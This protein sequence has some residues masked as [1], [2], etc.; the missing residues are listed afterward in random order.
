M[1]QLGLEAIDR[2]LPIVRKKYKPDFILAQGENAYQGKGI[3]RELYA[4]LI[5]KGIDFLTGGNWTL[6]NQDIYP[7]LE[8]NQKMILRPA[9]YPEGTVGKK[10]KFLKT[11][12]GDVLVVSILGNIVGKDKDLK[13]NNPLVEIDQILIETKAIPKIATLVNFHGDYSSQKIVFGH[14]LDG[15]VTAVIGDHWH[16]PSADARILKRQTAYISDVGMVGSLNSSLGVKVEIILNRWKKDIK[17]RNELEEK[18]DLQLNG[19]Y[20]E[21]DPN[22]QKSIKSELI[23]RYFTLDK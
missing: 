13:L 18:D 15:K 23:Q 1:G 3:T 7:Y 12:Q 8:D 10:Y 16:V 22:N 2:L 20:V 9:N 6:F 4:T 19:I 11:K 17:Q 5:D 21:F 14:Y